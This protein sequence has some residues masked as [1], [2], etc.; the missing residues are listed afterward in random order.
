LTDFVCRDCADSF[1]DIRDEIVISSTQLC[2]ALAFGEELEIDDAANCR[3]VYSQ[4]YNG[5]R[6]HQQCCGQAKEICK[7]PC[8]GDD[9]RLYSR[10]KEVLREARKDP[11]ES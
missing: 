7:A 6:L 10:M 2:E 4:G 9:I 1:A 3:S 8:E 5:Q 11:E